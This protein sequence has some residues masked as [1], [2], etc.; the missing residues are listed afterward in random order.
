MVGKCY[1][2]GLLPNEGSIYG[3]EWVQIGE[4]VDGEEREM[5]ERQLGRG[6]IEANGWRGD[7][8]WIEYG[9]S[10][11]KKWEEVRAIGRDGR[12]RWYKRKWFRGY[13]WFPN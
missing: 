12:N 10:R 13:G 3:V 5:L 8:G 9:R 7:G 1:I 2:G 4:W 11:W 6:L